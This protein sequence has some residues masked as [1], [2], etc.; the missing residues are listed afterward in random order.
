MKLLIIGLAICLL[1]T[2]IGVGEEQDKEIEEEL[3]LELNTTETEEEQTIEEL[4]ENR[5]WSKIAELMNKDKAKVE[6]RPNSLESSIKPVSSNEKWD[7]WFAP[8]EE[9]GFIII[10]CGG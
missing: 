7:N 9:E 10:P 2:S 6:A 4:M 8:K 5:D 3:P 1:F